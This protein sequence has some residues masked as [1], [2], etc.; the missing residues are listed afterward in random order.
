MKQ[1]NVNRSPL[2]YVGDKYKLID[3]IKTHFPAGIG[4][5]IEPFVGGGSVF[6]NVD[7]DEYLL[8]TSTAR[9]SA[10]TNTYAQEPITS[11]DSSTAFSR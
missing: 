1:K 9:S 2:F 11:R 4:R 5:F 7:A 3:E 10:S 6:M 8:T